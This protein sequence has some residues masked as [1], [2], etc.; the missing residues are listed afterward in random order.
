ML[1]ALRKFLFLRY[2][3]NL[4]AVIW[5][6]NSVKTKHLKM[7]TLEQQRADENVLKLVEKHKV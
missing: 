7:A 1:D 3:Y 2:A 6:Q 4:R 5:M